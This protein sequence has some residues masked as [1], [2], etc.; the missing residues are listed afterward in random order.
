MD[1][2]LLQKD[3]AIALTN[4]EWTSDSEEKQTLGLKVKKFLHLNIW[5]P[6]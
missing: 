5:E 3:W 6:R 2:S 1:E 4:L